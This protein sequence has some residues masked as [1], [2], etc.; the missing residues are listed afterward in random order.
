[1][2]YGVQQTVTAPTG[3]TVPVGCPPVG[4]HDGVPVNDAPTSSTDPTAP[5]SPRHAPLK[6]VTLPMELPQAPS[7]YSTAVPVQAMGVRA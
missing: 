1:V 7:E 6:S 3:V 4:A 5:G 2:L